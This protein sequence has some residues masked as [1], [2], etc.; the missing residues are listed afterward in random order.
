MTAIDHAKFLIATKQWDEAAALLE[1]LTNTGDR[2][3]D[4][5]YGSLLFG[6]GDVPPEAALEALRRAAA[7][8]HPAACY[9]VSTT[10]IDDGVVTG[11]IV[12]RDLFI[13]FIRAAHLIP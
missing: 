3:A 6:G 2:E 5:L 10:T 7:L 1:P 4:Y 12:D 11:P 8:D 13:R 9:A